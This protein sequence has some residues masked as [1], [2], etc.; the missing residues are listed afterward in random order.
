MLTSPNKRKNMKRTAMPSGQR[1]HVNRML[2]GSKYERKYLEERKAI[3]GWKVEK[4][5]YHDF[6]TDEQY[7]NPAVIDML[8][9]R[10]D[11]EEL[12]TLLEN[13]IIG[14]PDFI[15]INKEGKLWFEEFKTLKATIKDHQFSTAV[16]LALVGYETRI[17]RYAEKVWFESDQ[18]KSLED[19]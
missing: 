9:G 8:K 13:R 17:V 11:E 4:V 3:E 19:F 2:Q 18:N 6:D 15:I 12:I 16:R 10:E 7:L 5:A 14:A 1:K